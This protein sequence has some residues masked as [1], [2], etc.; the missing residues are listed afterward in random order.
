MLS[1]ADFPTLPL[2]PYSGIYTRCVKCG[3]IGAPTSRYVDQRPL[4]TKVG[5]VADAG[6]ALEYQERSCRNCGFTWVEDVAR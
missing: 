4:L 1:E 5:A 3:R 2:P 6:L